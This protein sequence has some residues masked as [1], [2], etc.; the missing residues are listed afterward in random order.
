[1]QRLTPVLAA[2]LLAVTLGACASPPAPTPLTLTFAFP[3]DSA[4]RTAA[5]EMQRAFAASNPAVTIVLRP[6]PS[7]SYAEALGA[8]LEA[9][10]PPDVFVHEA[11]QVPALQQRGA[12][13]DLTPLGVSAADLNQAALEPWRHD[14]L[15]LGLPQRAVPTMLFYNRALLDAEGLSIPTG[16]W[17]W[18]DWRDAA[19]RLTDESQGRYGTALVGWDGLVWGNGGEIFDAERTRTLLDQPA[20]AAGV[21]FGADMI[22]IDRSAPL[23]QSAGGPDPVALFR[24]GKLA[25]L[26]APSNLIAELEQTPPSFAWDIAPLPVGSVR[27]TRLLV[28]GLG[29]SARTPHPREAAGF[30]SWAAGQD[31][32]ATQ[33]LAFPFAVP[34]R[35]DV[36]PATMLGGDGPQGGH[37]VIEAL[38]YGRVQPFVLRW[39]EIASEVNQALMPVW[40]GQQTASNAYQ[41]IAP[42]VNGRLLTTQ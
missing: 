14:D 30:V 4:S 18:D 7:A 8:Q 21:Q 6:L 3:D 42:T 9:A 36:A 37:F 26:P 31:G 16:G 24:A 5:E 32:L 12:L 1:M 35:A 22:N 41:Q 38:G 11:Q 40:Q 34:A 33:V 28:S 29:A 13:L 19:R 15:L 2:F 27:V 39:P 20:A 25:T 17:A 10:D 23:P